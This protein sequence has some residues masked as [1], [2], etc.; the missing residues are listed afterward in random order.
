MTFRPGRWISSADG[1]NNILHEEVNHIPVGFIPWAI[2][3]RSCPGKKF[4]QVEFIA[5]ISL[6]FRQHRVKPIK[7]PGETAE[8]VKKRVHAVIDD[9]SMKA[10]LSMNHPGKSILWPK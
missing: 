5:V 7:K 2:G 1:T 8:E 10:T 4:S 6:L 9:S 3:P